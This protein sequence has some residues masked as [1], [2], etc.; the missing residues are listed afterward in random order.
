MANPSRLTTSRNRIGR[1]RGYG[2]CFA[3]GVTWDWKEHHTTY[4]KPSDGCF[5]L[6]EVCWSN[7][8]PEERL[9]FYAELMELWLVA[10]PHCTREEKVERLNDWPLIK[11]AVE[12]GL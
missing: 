7:R 11:A 6:C 10:Q 8:T 5:A 9:P 12:A 2:G 3:C 4:Y 1:A